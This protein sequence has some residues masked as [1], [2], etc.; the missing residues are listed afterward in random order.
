M[1]QGGDG[2]LYLSNPPQGTIVNIQICPQ[3]ISPFLIARFFRGGDK[4]FWDIV[5]RR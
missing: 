4:A 5:K 1:F 2:L 3:S